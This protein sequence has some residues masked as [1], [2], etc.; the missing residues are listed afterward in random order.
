MVRKIAGLLLVVILIMLVAGMILSTID[1][2]KQ[3]HIEFATIEA[4]YNE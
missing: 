4:R 2:S 1:V 3:A